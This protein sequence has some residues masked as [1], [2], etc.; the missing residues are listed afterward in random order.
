MANENE[1]HQDL[2]VDLGGPPR[3]VSATEAAHLR[4]QS[5]AEEIPV[6]Y[7]S[8]SER[9]AAEKD[10]KMSPGEKL[11]M[12]LTHELASG[13]LDDA[14]RAAKL[15]ELK[16][17]LVAEESQ[18]E[19]GAFAS[20]PL[21]DQREAFGLEAPD[22]PDFLAYEERYGAWEQRF[23]VHAKNDGLE[24]SVVKGIRDLGVKLGTKVG[25]TGRPIEDAEL[26]HAL[27]RFNLTAEQR[28]GLK[29][30]WRAIEGGGAA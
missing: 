25:M 1:I 21:A 8:E 30:Y 5:V 24:S 20:A 9:R 15:A 14:T 22:I 19:Q 13:T 16:K 10:A 11:R 27:A 18:E 17:S 7:T 6:K 2:G 26:D 12:E 29:K 28:V 3:P 4:R 23:L